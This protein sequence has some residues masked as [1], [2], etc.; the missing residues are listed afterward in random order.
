M[1]RL[2]T[3]QR[4]RSIAEV[5]TDRAILGVGMRRVL[6]ADHA[7]FGRLATAR[8][9]PLTSI[10]TIVTDAGMDSILATRLREQGVEVIIG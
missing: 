1:S 5:M 2:L 7:K 8:V 3:K 10:H 6:V 9:A 4:R